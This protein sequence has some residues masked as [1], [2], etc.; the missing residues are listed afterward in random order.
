MNLESETEL[1]EALEQEPELQV[2]EL[3]PQPEKRW[4]IR[5][6]II[7]TSEN[8]MVGA[9]FELVSFSPGEN[10]VLMMESRTHS[11][12]DLNVTG[13]T[14]PIVF[15]LLEHT[16]KLVEQIAGEQGMLNP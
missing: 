16:K 12:P 2:E 13:Y 15:S 11:I 6:L 9:I 10:G 14:Y 1:T 3:E 8:G 7:Q 4:T 5:N